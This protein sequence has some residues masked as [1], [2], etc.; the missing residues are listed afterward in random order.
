MDFIVK[1]PT[2]KALW[3]SNGNDDYEEPRARKPEPL[4]KVL[5]NS[6]IS[7][8]DR[9]FLITEGNKIAVSSTGWSPQTVVGK[10]DS[11]HLK[12]RI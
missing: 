7:N 3:A 5:E 10:D 2:Q 9:G 4:R 1:S 11:R 8:T 6:Q 12:S